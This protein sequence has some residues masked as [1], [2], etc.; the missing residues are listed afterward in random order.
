MLCGASAAAPTHHVAARDI[1]IGAGDVGRLLTEEEH[2]CLD[3]LFHGAQSSQWHRVHHLLGN[4]FGVVR[5][6]ELRCTRGICLRLEV[7]LPLPHETVLRPNKGRTHG[8]HPHVAGRQIQGGDLREVIHSGLARPVR[9]HHR[10]TTQASTRCRVDNRATLLLDHHL[11]H[12][13]QH[14]ED[15]CDVDLHDLLEIF[16]AVRVNGREQALVPSV[17]KETVDLPKLLLNFLDHS[18]HLLF[19]RDINGE[20]S[21]LGPISLLDF[22]SNFTH[23]VLRQINQRHLG[24][25]SRQHAGADRAEVAGGAGDDHHLAI[26]PVAPRRVLSLHPSSLCVHGVGGRGPMGGNGRQ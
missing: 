25:L 15:A 23:L 26:E 22:L 5:E 9:R 7:H 24:A 21:S 12:V 2:D 10:G 1:D 3:D 19:L 18:L 11:R 6:V 17:V 8:V 4:L 14:R 16:E 20:A 13:L